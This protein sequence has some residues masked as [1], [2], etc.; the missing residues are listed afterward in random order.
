M[1]RRRKANAA[2]GVD[3]AVDE[4]GATGEED[5]AALDGG[6]AF[7]GE[8]RSD[9]GD[10]GEGEKGQEDVVLLETGLDEIPVLRDVVVL[11]VKPRSIERTDS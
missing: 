7:D 8:E 5:A 2:V 3:A 11:E 4:G 10:E 9:A 6:F 1:R